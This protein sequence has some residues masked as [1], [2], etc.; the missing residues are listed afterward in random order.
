MCIQ[1]QTHVDTLT[2]KIKLFSCPKTWKTQKNKNKLMTWTVNLPWTI[3]SQFG[4]YF[5]KGGTYWCGKPWFEECT[6]C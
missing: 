4:D 2:F 1:R 3:T 6:I 5:H